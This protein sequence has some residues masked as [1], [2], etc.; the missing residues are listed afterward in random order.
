MGDWSRE[1]Y[2]WDTPSGNE[3]GYAK[4]DVKPKPCA[5]CD[6]E[7]TTCVSARGGGS[8][9]GTWCEEEFRCEECGVFSTYAREYES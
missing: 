7:D 1:V 6:S 3:E 2:V 5:A 4:R 9:I 8:I